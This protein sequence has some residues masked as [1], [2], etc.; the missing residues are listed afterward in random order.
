M[1][2][3]K[4]SQVA[5]LF[6][7][8]NT[9]ITNW[10][11]AA[12]KKQN[13]LQLTSIGKRKVIIDSKHNR[14][15]IRRLKVRGRKHIGRS[16]R[17]LVKPDKKLQE[18]LTQK[19]LSELYC[20]LSSRKEIPYKFS[21]LYKGADLW[22]KSYRHMLNSPKDLPNND[23]LKE[24]ELIENHLHGLINRFKIY[25]TINVIDIGCGNGLPAVHIIKM[26][27]E[28]GFK[29]NYTAVDISPRMIEI[30]KK[31]VTDNFPDIL[32]D[33]YVIDLDEENFADL[34]VRKKVN[35][36]N[37]NLL[38]F[39]GST[40][41]NYNK[42]NIIFRNLRNSMSPHDYLLLGNALA[43]EN[44]E[45]SSYAPNE[46]H[47]AR[48]TWL[49]DLLGLKGMYPGT[50]LTEIK[51]SKI[52]EIREIPIE[53]NVTVNFEVEKNIFPININEFD[54]ILVYKFAYYKELELV[55]QVIE[56][57]FRIEQFTTNRDRSYG[58]MVVTV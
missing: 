29:V 35:N 18:I 5:K 24:S 47:F 12:E 1:S 46:Y 49:M 51:K 9:T 44:V 14:E 40:L 22:D 28:A 55:H 15:I 10:I 30:G 41:G 53:R 16:N 25:E 8:S 45:I 39:L 2:F 48:T 7:V 57:G 11:D 38:L 26:L 23:A 20:S 50:V 31:E 33:E 34:T 21:Y 32:A 58:I 27:K 4:N 42:D 36:K 19:Q 3:F 43:D 37:A 54:R 52:I 17:I 13:D 6:K 56:S